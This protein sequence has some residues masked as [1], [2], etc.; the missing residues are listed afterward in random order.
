M[1]RYSIK[2]LE[3]LSGIKAHTIRIWEKRYDLIEPDRTETNIRYYSD[4]DLKKIINVSILNANGWKISKIAAMSGDTIN[5]EVLRLTQQST[6]FAVHID[7]LIIAMTDLD[8]EYFER[9]LSGL[10]FR[11]S[12]EQT[13]TEIIYPFLEKIGVLW[14]TE[15]ISPAHEHFISNLIRQKLMVAIDS[16]PIPSKTAKRAVLFLPEHELH[17]MGLL[18]GYYLLR[19]A[20][21]RVLY[22]GQA[23]PFKDLENVYDIF[24][25]EI[26]L[27]SLTTS[28]PSLFVSDLLSRLTH[29]FAK[30]KIFIT[31][32]QTSETMPM[33]ENVQIL[34]DFRQLLDIV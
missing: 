8:E 11:F 14:Q 31:G 16:L 21:V 10:I 3:K 9:T 15:N 4:N 12:F 20:G 33:A 22:L 30:S 32:R 28:V 24:Q 29:D 19:K 34:T 6:E 7:Q 26:L 13:V 23:V 18:F 17:E 25:P 1:G 5:Q 2:E 27:T